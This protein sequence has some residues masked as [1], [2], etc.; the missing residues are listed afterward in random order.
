M[1]GKSV[2]CPCR[3]ICYIAH[4]RFF[5]GVGSGIGLCVVPIFL[6]EIA[7]PQISN[8]VGVLTQ[9]SIV[10]GIMV[11]Q[12]LG[13]R[14]AT[15]TEWRAVFFFSFALCTAQFLLSVF[16]VES[17]IWLSNRGRRDEKETVSAKLWGTCKGFIMSCLLLLMLSLSSA[18]QAARLRP[19]PAGPRGG[20][21]RSSAARGR[22]STSV[23]RFQVTA[24][25][26]VNHMFS[27]GLAAIVRSVNNLLCTSHSRS[28]HS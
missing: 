26:P 11:T 21:L 18:K 10:I 9:L 25:T 6:A 16:I 22:D 28:C 8:N 14:L 5:V 17:P 24:A 15:P 27:D 3:L 20:A 13:L 23:T 4:C 2:L 12:A 1:E 7:P 19:P